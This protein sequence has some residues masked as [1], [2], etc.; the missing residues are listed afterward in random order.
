VNGQYGALIIREP[1]E[2][3]RNSQYYSFDEIPHVVFASDWLHRMAESYV[4][5]PPSTTLTVDSVLING[6]GMHYNVNRILLQL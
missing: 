3:D 6:R 1:K 2:I 5:G 4:P